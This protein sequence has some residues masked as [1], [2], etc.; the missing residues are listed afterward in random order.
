MDGLAFE[1]FVECVLWMSDNGTLIFIPPPLSSIKSVTTAKPIHAF[2]LT[3]LQANRL[4]RRTRP[5]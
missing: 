3:L 2:E 4:P 1:K 5:G